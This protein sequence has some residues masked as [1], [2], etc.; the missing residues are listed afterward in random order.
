MSDIDFLPASYRQMTV[1][2]KA[3]VWRLLAGGIF[4]ALIGFSGIYQ[5]MLR[6]QAVAELARTGLQYDRA[7]AL[8]ARQAEL[9]RQLQLA[10]HEADLLTY[11]RHPWPTTQVLAAALEPLPDCITLQEIRLF[12]GERPPAIAA[13][14][15]Q[16]DAEKKAS[17]SRPAAQRDLETLRHDNEGRPRLLVLSGVTTNSAA[18]QQYVL[19]LGQS[20]LFLKTE[21]SKLEADSADQTGSMHFTARLVVR[22][23]YGEAGGPP[24]PR[25]AKSA[26]DVA[27][28]TPAPAGQAPSETPG[29]RPANKAANTSKAAVTAFR[30]AR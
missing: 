18:L 14:K 9:K 4:V 8:V 26:K 10:A 22:P 21:L 29:D 17:E 23:G 3:N 1:H 25:D 30:S 11:L 27:L 12:Q 6:R 2:R 5:H 13:A 20:D 19:A 7:Q 28:P 15:P 16:T 24:I